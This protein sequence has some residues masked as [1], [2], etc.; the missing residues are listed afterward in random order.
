MKIYAMSY[1]YGDGS[2]GVVFYKNK[3]EE[4]DLS[5]HEFESLIASL[6]DGTW[7]TFPDDFDFA[8]AGIRLKD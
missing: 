7:L 2:A 8:A 3:P 1:D 5:E 4:E 6:H